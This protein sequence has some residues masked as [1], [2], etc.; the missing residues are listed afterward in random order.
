VLLT[1]EPLVMRCGVAED[2]NRH[3]AFLDPAHVS[4]LL[5]LNAGRGAAFLDEHGLITDPHRF[6]VS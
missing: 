3:A 6:R 1:F 4:G 2:L 5:P